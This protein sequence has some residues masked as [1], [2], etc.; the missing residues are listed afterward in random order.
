[1]NDGARV[2]ADRA[3]LARGLD[4]DGEAYVGPV[5]ERRRNANAGV[6]KDDRRTRFVEAEAQA[7]RGVAGERY[8][9]ALQQR[10]HQGLAVASALEGLAR[11]ED[12][13]GSSSFDDLNDVRRRHDVLDAHRGANGEGFGQVRHDR[14][15]VRVGS[16]VAR[17]RCQ[18]HHPLRVLARTGARLCSRRQAHVAQPS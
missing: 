15:E 14:V 18:Q 3:V 6:T 1:V 5:F 10:R 8:A 17:D 11:V 9:H 12:D 4:D 16:Q 2:D 7:A 13:V